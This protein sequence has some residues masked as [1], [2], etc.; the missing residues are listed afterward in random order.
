[1]DDLRLPNPAR[2]LWL[3]T[4]D[5]VRRALEQLQPGIEYRIGGGTVLAALWKHRG[6]FDVDLQVPKGTKLAE[7]QGAAYGWLH[8]ELERLGAKPGYRPRLNLFTITRGEEEPERQEVQVWAHEPEIGRGH[9]RV[10]VEGRE[11]TVL[12]TAQILAGKLKRA[13]RHPAR[14]VYDVAKAAEVE[15]VSLEIAVNTVPHDV[16]GEAALTWIV[17]Y[18]KIGSEAH[19]RL[20]GLA[21]GEER[22][23]YEIGKTGAKALLEARY[24]HLR[25]GIEDDRI[26]VEAVTHGGTPRRL[27]MA[28]GEA[29]EQ[30]EAKGI[31]GHLRDKGPG[32]RALREYAVALCRKRTGDVLVFEETED[33]ET[34]WRTASSSRNLTII[35]PH[36]PGRIKGPGGGWERGRPAWGR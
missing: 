36:R 23:H 19:Q 14:D 5:V 34:R 15:P 29:E 4:R 24:A 25:L 26:V 11:E 13:T 31:N 16:V 32:A 7:L 10:P 12:S 35:A 8:A 17:S 33:K 18:G 1:M 21:P 28:A 27:T 30:F 20:V 3:E 6:S 9:A 22:R 2:E